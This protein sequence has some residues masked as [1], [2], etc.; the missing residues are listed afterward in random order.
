MILVIGGRSKIG[1]ALINDLVARDETVRAVVRPREAEAS[2]PDAVERVTGDLADLDSLRSAFAGVDRVFLLC[3]PTEVDTRDVAAVAAAV[4]TEAGDTGSVYD[5]TGPEAVSY[6]DVASALT[7]ALKR[8][9]TY[10]DVPDEA[11]SEALAGLGLTA[12]LIGALVELFQDYRRSGAAGYA[13]QVTD[14]IRAVTGKVPR[15]LEQ[16]LAELPAGAPA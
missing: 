12:W 10:V 15:K 11:T 13:A 3:G 4:L 16:L 14:P 1:S 9:I 7:K 2:L 5:V 8:E 6:A